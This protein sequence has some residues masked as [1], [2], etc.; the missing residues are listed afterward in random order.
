[1]QCDSKPPTDGLMFGVSGPS[2]M[3]GDRGERRRELYHSLQTTCTSEALSSSHSL[4]EDDP[5]PTASVSCDTI[6][7][8]KTIQGMNKSIPRMD[9]TGI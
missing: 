5:P 4:V 1:M 8:L 2:C 7:P 3:G 9:Y 6:A